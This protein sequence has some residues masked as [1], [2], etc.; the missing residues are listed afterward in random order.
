MSLYRRAIVAVRGGPLAGHWLFAWAFFIQLGHLIE[1]ISVAIEGKAL[2]GSHFGSELSHLL[3]NGL[4][5]IHRTPHP[6]QRESNSLLP[7]RCVLCFERYEA[8][9]ACGSCDPR[10]PHTRSRNDRYVTAGRRCVGT[11]REAR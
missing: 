11:V 5:A 9:P 7:F 4:I 10:D 2:L 1:H 3:F 6:C 8:L